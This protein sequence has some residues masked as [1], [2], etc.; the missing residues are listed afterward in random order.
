MTI[1][2]RTP[3]TRKYPAVRIRFAGRILFTAAALLGAENV[4][5]ASGDGAASSATLRISSCW[6][7]RLSRMCRS[8]STNSLQPFART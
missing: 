8:E 3:A 6:L 4:H 5:A 7:S 1:A 2:E